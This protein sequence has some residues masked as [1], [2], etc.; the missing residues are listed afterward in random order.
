MQTETNAQ[1][2]SFG[3]DRSSGQMKRSG[4]GDDDKKK[5]G[6]LRLLIAA[7]EASIGSFQGWVVAVRRAGDVAPDTSSNMGLWVVD[8]KVTCHIHMRRGLTIVFESTLGLG[9]DS[10]SA[11]LFGMVLL[12][13][14]ESNLFAVVVVVVGRVLSLGL[15]DKVGLNKISI[16][17]AVAV[18]EVENE[19]R[20]A[21]VPNE[22]NRRM[23]F[24]KSSGWSRWY[25]SGLFVL[26]VATAGFLVMYVNRQ[27]LA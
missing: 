27:I 18:V 16:A 26:A 25:A 23:S 9:L 7:L 24:L 6:N 8:M 4:D 3:G 5:K 1:T 17:T 19:N 14:Q 13:G 11:V 2:R 12:V 22:L 21:H 10:M 20:S 15:W